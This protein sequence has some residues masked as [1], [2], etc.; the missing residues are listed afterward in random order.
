MLLLLANS[1]IKHLLDCHIT[2]ELKNCY[3][4]PKLASSNLDRQACYHNNIP[5][6]L[7]SRVSHKLTFFLVIEYLL[8]YPNVVEFTK[9]F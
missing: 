4:V 6:R 5:S 7:L 8:I 1:A 9:G 3:K 2:Q